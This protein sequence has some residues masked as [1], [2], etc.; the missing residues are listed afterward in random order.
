MVIAQALLVTGSSIFLV[1][2]NLH[3][4]YTF[5]SNKFQPR[6]PSVENEMNN[7]S[8]YITR[9]TTMWRAW[10]GFN[11]SHS[12]GAIF[13]GAI[14]LVLAT[15]VFDVFQQ[16]IFLPVIIL[17]TLL[18]YLFLAR[19]YWFRIPFIG[20]SLANLCFIVAFVIMYSKS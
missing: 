6:D 8:P 18:F 5:F 19:N 13:F 14:N 16:S 7:T 17:I 9:Q 15:S 4:Y 1:L 12:L 10:I 11:A 3:L 2:G 20:I